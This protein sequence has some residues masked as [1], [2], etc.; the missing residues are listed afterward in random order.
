MHTSTHA[1]AEPYSAT[2]LKHHLAHAEAHLKKAQALLE[3]TD[4][5]AGDAP[6][7]GLAHAKRLRRLSA[8][9]ERLFTDAAIAQMHHDRKA[10]HVGRGYTA[11]LRPGEERRGW[12]DDEVMADLI[13]ATVDRALARHPYLPPKAAKALLTEA[14]WTVYKAGRITWRSTSLRELGLDPDDY[15]HHA[16]TSPSLD[17]RGVSTHAPATPTRKRLP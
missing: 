11:V 5:F 10:Y 4:D 1:G 9:I 16:P 3:V 8:R 2:A 7:D 12:R 17:M 13:A 14:M 15:S 6:F